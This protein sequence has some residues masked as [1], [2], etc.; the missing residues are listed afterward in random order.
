[1]IRTNPRGGPP[2]SRAAD[3]FPNGSDW[4]RADPNVGPCAFDFDVPEAM[5]PP[6]P[7]FPDGSA[8]SPRQ[9]Q[10][11]FLLVRTLNMEEWLAGM[12]YQRP[13]RVG[14]L[15]LSYDAKA[16]S[17]SRAGYKVAVHLGQKVAKLFSALLHVGS[18]GLE[19]FM[20]A[21]VYP[22][23]LEARR[24]AKKE[25]RAQLAALNVTVERGKWRLA[26]G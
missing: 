24:T 12:G 22:G 16:R 11:L 23:T 9:E 7:N 8:L 13:T 26:E 18:D 20:L 17:V 19:D 15:G 5:F 3:L 4:L 2:K 1:M 6:C 10:K 14:Y 21:N 25:L